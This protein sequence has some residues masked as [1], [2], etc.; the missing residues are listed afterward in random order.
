[1]TVGLELMSGVRWAEG[2]WTAVITPR[3][4]MLLPPSVPMDLVERLWTL[5]RSSEGTLTTVLDEFVMGMGGRLGSIPDF[6]LVAP[7][8]EGAIRLALRGEVTVELDGETLDARGVITWREAAVR[9]TPSVR[10]RTSEESPR[11]V[12]R[13]AADAVVGACMVLLGRPIGAR[14]Q[15]GRRSATRRAL[16]NDDDA[17]APAP[18][19]S[20]AGTSRP[21][22]HSLRA[23]TTPAISPGLTESPYW[24][25]HS[26]GVP[27]TTS[28]PSSAEAGGGETGGGS[29]APAVDVKAPTPASPSSPAEVSEITLA[30]AAQTRVPTPT[31]PSSPAESAE[32]P[33]STEISGASAAIGAESPAAGVSAVSPVSPTS[34]AEPAEAD[35]SGASDA[36]AV[37]EVSGAAEA[38][39]AADPG[40]GAAAEE[41]SPVSPTSPAESVAYVPA[42]GFPVSTPVSPTSPAEPAEAD[43]S[44]VSEVF[45]AS[46]AAEADSAAES[47]EGAAAEEVSPVSPTSPAESVAYV[48]AHGFPVSTPVSPTSPAEPAEADASGASEAPGGG[49]ALGGVSWDEIA[50]TVEV[51][52]PTPASSPSPAE[53]FMTSFAPAA[54]ARPAPASSPAQATGSLAY[55]AVRSGVM[56]SSPAEAVPTPVYG[57]RMP[58]PAS[59]ASPGDSAA[60]AHG[61]GASPGFLDAAD[62]PRPGAPDPRA[63]RP[64]DHDGHTVAGLPEDLVAELAPLAAAAS[65]G[66]PVE[67]GPSEAAQ[68]RMVLSA[69]CAQG[70]PNPTNY[71]NCRVC[72][73]DLNR[74]ARPCPCPPLG[75]VVSSAGQSLEL[76]GPVL[77]G[78]DPTAGD[79]RTCTGMPPRIMSVPSP[80]HLISRNHV[81]IDVDEWSVL[82]QD[83]SNANGTVLIREGAAPIRLSRTEPA[84]LRSGDILDLGDGQSLIL[85]NLP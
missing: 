41:V 15:A 71:T 23:P 57:I 58:T 49:G 59:P 60:F 85:E 28:P 6:V 48:P 66:S 21:P 13:P 19:P 53:A 27:T 79:V 64:G 52:R 16:R 69:V 42:H 14:R 50:P 62:V 37:S 45:D 17:K 51:Q 10:L 74:P 70:H 82:A 18:P 26:V 5:L 54:E 61:A 32:A 8:A 2:P 4:A 1:M 25:A 75:R 78:R 9:G 67:V 29:A 11:I 31:S 76:S 34:P 84:L 63:D 35:A 33:E 30:P 65:G 44:G 46:G 83:L 47:G 20:P 22:G 39:G 72:G 56:E 38:D 81:L 80:E 36:S 77:V 3:G 55:G 68:V 12:L 40:E 43:V 7:D 24:P 73:R